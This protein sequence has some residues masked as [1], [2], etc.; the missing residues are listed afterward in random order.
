M[1]KIGTLLF[2]AALFIILSQ[3]CKAIQDKLQFHFDKSIFKGLKSKWWNPSLSWKN[4]H[5][6]SK[7]RVIKWLLTNPLVFVTDAWHFFGFLRFLFVILALFVIFFINNLD[8]WIIFTYLVVLYAKARSSFHL[9][10]HYI[11]EVKGL[12]KI[13]DKFKR[14]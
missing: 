6:W 14:K 7:N 9:F 1:I 2:V 5:T 11:F 3:V 10:F 13:I 8:F 12:R 4:K